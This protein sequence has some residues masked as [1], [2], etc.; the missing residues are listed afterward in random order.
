M[1]KIILTFAFIFA[2]MS[3]A[4]ARS[5][6][7]VNGMV[8]DF[9][10]QALEKVFGKKEEVSSIEVNLDDQTVIIHYSEGLGP[11]SDEEIGKAVY[12]AG[13]NIVSIQ[14]DDSN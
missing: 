3:V 1:K 9:C 2:F 4:H 5:V 11:L 12:W 6:V 10:A 13:Y 7:N 8:C 14:N